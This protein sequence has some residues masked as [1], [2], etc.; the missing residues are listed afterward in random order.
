MQ[1]IVVPL[2]ELERQGTENK[3]TTTSELYAQAVRE[4]E[5]IRQVLAPYLAPAAGNTARV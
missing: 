1:R 4:F 5:L 3:L 2:R